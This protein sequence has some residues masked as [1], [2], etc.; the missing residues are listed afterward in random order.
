M[1]RLQYTPDPTQGDKPL[2]LEPN[3]VFVFAANQLG[4]HGG[5]SARAALDQYNAVYGE[6]HRTGRC[7]G[8]VTLNFPTGTS[9]GQTAIKAPERITQEEL[10]K[11]FKL[12]I[13]QTIIEKE[14]TFYLTKVGIG[15]A[16]WD[17][18]DV[19]KALAK[20]YRPKR[21]KNIVL[22]KEFDIWTK[23]IPPMPGADNSVLDTD[24]IKKA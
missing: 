2:V 20:H 12:F 13:K 11:E 17:I 1:A 7:Y 9:E 14:K 21:H 5:G 8:L 6:I 4:H 19:I 23:V 22:P 3:E 16:G 24:S 18:K 10:E 15:I